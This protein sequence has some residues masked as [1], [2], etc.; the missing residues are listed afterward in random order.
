MSIPD[1]PSDAVRTSYRC[2]PK[3]RLSTRVI[4]NSSSMTKMRFGISSLFFRRGQ[5]HCKPRREPVRSVPHRD[6]P[7]L[8]FH[9][10]LRDREPEPQAAAGA[11]DVLIL[12]P[13]ELVE[14]PIAHLTRDAAA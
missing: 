2:A 6:R 11:V 14:Y 5:R 4:W 8:R 1:S 9:Y 7:A 3:L 13:H 10:P 12:Q